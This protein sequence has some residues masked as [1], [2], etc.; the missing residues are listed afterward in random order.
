M[1]MRKYRVMFLLWGKRV[2]KLQ[3]TLEDASTMSALSSK[4]VIING[5]R[6]CELVFASPESWMSYFLDDEKSKQE[7]DSYDFSR[8][9]R[10]LEAL[11]ESAPK[12]A[13][14]DESLDAHL[15]RCQYQPHRYVIKF[16]NEPGPAASGQVTT[17]GNAVEGEG[18]T[19]CTLTQSDVTEIQTLFVEFF[20]KNDLPLDGLECDVLGE[21]VNGLC[22]A[23]TNTRLVPTRKMARKMLKSPA[24]NGS[25]EVCRYLL[26]SENLT[27]S[28]DSL[29][30]ETGRRL[31]GSVAQRVD[32]P[33]V[34]YDFFDITDCAQD[35]NELYNIMNCM[36]SEDSDIAAFV[37][38]SA[39]VL[40]VARARV[41]AEYP[42]VVFLPCFA[43]EANLLIQDI[44]KL[45]PITDMIADANRIVFFVN[46]S[47][48]GKELVREAQRR[49]GLPR[50]KLASFSPTRWNDAVQMPQMFSEYIVPFVEVVV[51]ILMETKAGSEARETAFNL[52]NSLDKWKSEGSRRKELETIVVLFKRLA[53]IQED[54]QSKNA[55]LYEVLPAFREMLI[56]VKRAF[57]LKFHVPWANVARRMT[58]YW[59]LDELV[60]AFY[61]HP[62][63][64]LGILSYDVQLAVQTII[65]PV[66]SQR[67]SID[68][69]TS[70]YEVSNI[71][72][73][74]REGNDIKRM[75][76]WDLYT[77]M[78]SPERYWR[79]L[80]EEGRAMLYGEFGYRL[81]CICPNSAGVEPLF[82]SVR[83]LH[84]SQ[85][86]RF[87]TETV[88]SVLHMRFAKQLTGG[89]FEDPLEE[90]RPLAI[91]E[92]QN[93]TTAGCN[94]NENGKR[95]E[96]S[97]GND[98]TGSLGPLN[99]KNKKRRI[100]TGETV[101]AGLGV[102]QEE[103][104]EDDDDDDI[105]DDDDE[106]ENEASVEMANQRD[107]DEW[108]ALI[109]CE[110]TDSVQKVVELVHYMADT[111]D[112][113]DSIPGDM[114]LQSVKAL[115]SLNC[116][117]DFK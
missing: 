77:C 21:L 54:L 45:S 8:C 117:F 37:T 14:N 64:K 96:T 101:D 86:S 106:I 29:T 62:A 5:R 23:A 93:E 30:R 97:N 7:G 33:A 40:R 87:D 11:G 84:C 52:L 95:P 99:K 104:E 16:D 66:C 57:P 90:W 47:P 92:E 35:D 4:P 80:K 65:P 81:Y 61:M 116:L 51:R 113:D 105:E 89:E 102:Y 74:V 41:S 18:S 69:P 34:P 114:D 39:S 43:H 70:C 6:Y 110:E 42:R 55:K 12:L 22:P 17:E 94:S 103:E 79:A 68:D 15:A 107:Y 31:L 63:S 24:L 60:V 3:A 13:R 73:E 82:S 44:C 19:G 91:A 98:E 56:L 10:C 46:N 20:V 75:P 67:M 38:S 2:H 1:Y 100:E 58:S 9:R 25:A 78:R 59:G 49:H 27:L 88:L 26:A 53:K 48:T 28:L 71:A 112:S 85:G 32:G 108:N 76:N 50:R 72:S 36:L 109:T 111:M 115:K 83:G